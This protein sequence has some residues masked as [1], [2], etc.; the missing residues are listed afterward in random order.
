MYFTMIG[1]DGVWECKETE[2]MSEWI[3][4]RLDKRKDLGQTLEELL[5]ETVAKDVKAEK[6]TD[7]MSAILIKYDKKW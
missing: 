1:C 7:N 2:C 3:K 6:G 5:N 4:N